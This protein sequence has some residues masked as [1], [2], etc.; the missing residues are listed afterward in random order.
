MANVVFRRGTSAQLAQ[1]ANVDGQLLF[2]TDENKILMDDGTTRK[3]YGG[4]TQVDSALSSTSTNPLQNKIVYSSCVKY[5]DIVDS[6]ATIAS[7]TQNDIPVG[8]LAVKELN[9][10]LME[11]KDY[12]VISTEEHIIGSFMGKPLY[13]KTIV[14]NSLKNQNDQIV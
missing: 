7:I 4:D 13:S 1:I 11:L 3:Q 9:S 2:S 8:A 10:N 5:T 6:L 12:T 14:A